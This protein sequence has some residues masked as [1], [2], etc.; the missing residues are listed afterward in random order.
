M[1]QTPEEIRAQ[2]TQ[3]SLEITDLCRSF[4][5]L[6]LNAADFI[7]SGAT[8]AEV[9]KEIVKRLAKQNTPI[10][11]Q[12]VE[13]GQEEVDKFR[14]AASDAMSFRAGLRVEKAAAGSESL[15]GMTMI[16]LARECYQRTHGK[17][18]RG[19]DRKDLV[20]SV[21]S[22][23]DFPNILANVANKSLMTAYQSAPTTYQQW[24]KRG[25]LNDFKPALRVQVSEAPLL[26]KVT[27]GGE[28]KFISMS[29]AGEYI[30]L[31]KYGEL[32]SLTR[33]DIINDDLQALTDIPTK[34]GVASR[35]TINH[36]VYS[37]L[38]GNPKMSDGK[39]L[40][41]NDH[42]NIEAA[43]KTAPSK[44]AFKAAFIAMS[45][46]KGL[47]KEGAVPLNITPAFW[48]GPKALQFEAMQLVKSAVEVGGTN[49]TTNVLQ[50]LLEIIADAELDAVD[51]DAYYFATAPGFIDTIEVGFLN[52]VD[53]PYIETQPGFV[54]DGITY[55]VRSEFGVKALDFRGL[56]KN[57]GK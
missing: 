12:S 32:F 56:Y 28:Y 33:E 29:D 25:N 47:R 50:G 14:S 39:S 19:Y 3:R 48:I 41:S 13:V 24:T 53:T 10:E 9:N 31:E 46:Q 34:F 52:G 42:A 55:K 49:A 36:S 44:E 37:I 27:K 57:P 7:R 26:R 35:L 21:I 5:Q 18:F 16:D 17:A 8:I 11:T 40:F 15:R 43:V 30:Q 20:R 2:E 54:V 45:M 22:T 38:T 51:S 1:T 23:S 6:D 4:S